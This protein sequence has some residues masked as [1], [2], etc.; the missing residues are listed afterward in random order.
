MKRYF[1]RIL[2][3]LAFFAA[4]LMAGHIFQHLIPGF[5]DPLGECQLCNIYASSSIPTV[6][7]LLLVVYFICKVLAVIVSAES[8]Q[9]TLPKES[10]AP[11]LA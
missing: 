3:G 1:R 5:L 4:L 8:F 11:P 7:A 9:Y 6:A 10:R 2:F